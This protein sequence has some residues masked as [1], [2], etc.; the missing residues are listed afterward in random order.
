MASR[1]SSSEAQQA[2]MPTYGRAELSFVRG[3]GV[4][5]YDADE[6]AYLDMAAGIAVNNLGH[7]HP[8]LVQALTEQASRLWHV[9]NLYRIPGQEQ[10]ALRLAKAANLDHVFFCN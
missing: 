4:W 8:H 5:L 7:C 9:S 10:L 3:E 1:Q 6:R 2:V